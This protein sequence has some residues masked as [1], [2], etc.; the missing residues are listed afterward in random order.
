ME[1]FGRPSWERLAE[2]VGHAAGGA[3]K[4]KAEE[5]RREHLGKEELSITTSVLPS[6]PSQAGLGQE[7]SLS[8]SGIGLA[9]CYDNPVLTMLCINHACIANALNSIDKLC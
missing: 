1:K 6:S 2:A 5:I 4:K 8:P 9:S 3:D 7:S